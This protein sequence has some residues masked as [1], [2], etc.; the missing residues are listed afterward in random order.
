MKLLIDMNLSPLWAEVLRSAGHEVSHWAAVG[1]AVAEDEEL[2]AWARKAGCVVLTNDL[3]FG[4][5][6][7]AMQA[8]G[9]SVLQV[10][11]E[12]VSPRALGERLLKALERFEGDLLAGA[13]I[14]IDERRERA[15]LLPIRKPGSVPTN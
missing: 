2:M 1:R 10:R 12:D 3:D 8:E 4:A 11:T 15:R 14:T 5:I 6:L 9:P 13:L 7:A